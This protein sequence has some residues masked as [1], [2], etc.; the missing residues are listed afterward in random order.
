MTGLNPEILS[1]ITELGFENPTPIQEKTIPHILTSEKDLI[2]LAQTGTGKTAAF[3]LPIIQQV[4]TNSKN[5][6]SLI[7]CPTRELCMQISRDLVNY[8]KNVKN[9]NVVPVYGGASIDP[10]IKQLNRGAHI[11]V[12]TPGR[13]IDLIK[14]RKLKIANIRWIVLD[15]ADEML[16]MGFKEDLDT[17]LAETPSE[18]QTL[19]FSATMPNDIAN[20]T[21]KYMKDAEKITA[22]KKN[23]LALNINHAYFMVQARDRYKAL[24]RIVD[25]NPDVYG[26]VFCR[27]RR[28]TKEVADNLIQDGYNA[29]ALHGDLSQAQ[30]DHVMTR[31]R[32]KHLQ[33][34]V[35]TDVAARGLDVNDLTHVINFNLP[36]ELE[37]YIHRSGRT[38][39]AGKSG[40]SL[41]IIHSKESSKLRAIERKV[42]KTFEKLLVPG[43]KEICGKQLFTLIDKVEKIEI[44]EA[45]IEE[46][47][48]DIYKK[49][50]WL[51]REDLI[52]H[53]VSLEFNRF[54]AYYKNDKDINI[55]TKSD[56][57]E[58]R[59][60]DRDDRDRGDRDR[61]DRDGGRRDGGRERRS[62]DEFSRFFVNIGTKD[63]LN[64]A[65]LIGLVN[66]NL[67]ND[68][69]EIGKID[70]LRKF[71]FFEIEKKYSDDIINKLNK[72]EFEGISV[73]AELT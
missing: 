39:R 53:F 69:A 57:R 8:S 41:S 46:F 1:A 48:P 56:Q 6:Q 44:E 43:G 11:V 33:L 20:I 61:G 71:S 32:S 54:L 21:G 55:S 38:G 35:A 9:L 34:L 28:E 37:S 68:S 36:D 26:I 40:T 14:R 24:K 45:Q 49:L 22:G 16:N 25:V 4:D 52:K 3:G 30:R 10:Q 63:G 18:K 58:G 60:R 65:R 31:F 42:G 13:V 15:E 17:I 67:D 62:S 73:A 29:D 23:S 66:E 19:L 72:A 7:L 59:G 70:I 47:M 64:A 12:G 51:S 2:A 27:T 50:E 5:T